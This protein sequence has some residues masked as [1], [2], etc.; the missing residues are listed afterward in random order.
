MS[1][2]F[3]FAQPFAPGDV[4][5]GSFVQLRTK[6][7][8]VI[9]TQQDQEST[10]LQDG[11]WKTVAISASLPDMLVGI[12][13]IAALSWSSANGGTVMVTTS[14]AHNLSTGQLAYIN[15]VFPVAYEASGAIPVTVTG[16]K[17]L[18]YPLAANPGTASFSPSGATLGAVIEYD[19]YSVPGAPN[20][21][22]NVTL[23][24]LVANSDLKLYFTGYDLGTDTWEVSV[25]DIVANGAGAAW[26]PTNGPGWGTN[27][28]RGW[29]VIRSGPVCTEWRFW[30]VLRRVSDGAFHPWLRGVLFVRAWGAAGPYEIG[31]YW[32]MPNIWGPNPASGTPTSVDTTLVQ[33]SGD[34]ALADS[35]GTV[36]TGSQALNYSDSSSPA[37]FGAVTASIAPSGTISRD[38]SAQVGPL[39]SASTYSWTH[40][41]AANASKLIVSVITYT[42]SGVVAASKITCG[43]IALTRIDG[44][45]DNNQCDTE[46]WYLD[47]PPAGAQTIAV[48]L[49]G[50]ADSCRGMSVSYIG[51]APG[52][53]SHANGQS[54][55]GT[56]FSLATSVVASN[57]WLVGN[58]F[59]GS[60]TL[61]AATTQVPSGSEP[62]HV[63]IATLQNG[64]TVLMYYGG[65]NDFRTAATAGTNAI[66]LNS[67][68]VALNSSTGYATAAVFT[69]TANQYRTLF[70]IT[71]N[72]YTQSRNTTAD[73][74]AGGGVPVVLSSTGSLP[75]GLT[76]GTVY[77]LAGVDGATKIAFAADAASTLK[78]TDNSGFVVPN[79]PTVTGV[80]SG[81]MTI[82]P[83]SVCFPACAVPAFDQNCR[84]VWVN[85]TQPT[86]LAAH[87]FNYLTTK[88]RCI[89][90]YIPA[91]GT[92]IDNPVQVDAS[93]SGAAPPPFSQSSI[94]WPFQ[95]GG[96]GDSAFDDRIGWLTWHSAC[97]LYR[98]FDN[99]LHQAN[100]C[101]AAAYF[102][103]GYWTADETVGLYSVINNTTYPY[104]AA[105]AGPNARWRTGAV[106]TVSISGAQADTVGG[107]LSG[108]HQAA[109]WILPY[110][111]TGDF[112]WYE[113]MASFFATRMMTSYYSTLTAGTA[114]A[115]K[116]CINIDPTVSYTLPAGKGSTGMYQGANE[117]DDS[118]Q[119]RGIGWI[120]RIF[121]TTRHFMP[122]SRPE[123]PYFN[124][125]LANEIALM[126][127][128]TTIN[129]T[130]SALGFLEAENNQ[131]NAYAPF[132]YNTYMHDYAFL[133]WA[134][135]AWKG[136][137]PAA[138]HFFANFFARYCPGRAN[139]S[140]AGNPG[141]IY[142]IGVYEQVVVDTN[143]NWIQTWDASI[144][145]LQAYTAGG[146]NF[147]AMVQYSQGSNQATIVYVTN[148]YT[149]GVGCPANI[150]N[151]ADF[152][153]Y[154]IVESNNGNVLTLNPTPGSATQP[155]ATTG[156]SVITM[157][158]A[159]SS[160]TT[161]N[162]TASPA[163]A[164]VVVGMGVYN[165]NNP[166][167]IPTGSVGV[168]GWPMT[169]YVT[170]VNAGSV[171]LSIPLAGQPQTTGA[172][173]GDTIA[174]G[175]IMNFSNGGGT[176]PWPGVATINAT[177]PFTDTMT[178]QPGLGG[179]GN[180][181]SYVCTYTSALAM[182]AMLYQATGNSSLSAAASA[183]A[184]IRRRQYLTVLSDGTTPNPTGVLSF[185]NAPKYAI[186]AIAAG[187]SAP[188]APAMLA[189]AEDCGAGAA[190]SWAANP[191][192]DGVTQ[193]AVYRAPQGAASAA[194]VATVTSPG[195]TDTDGALA[196][197]TSW[198]YYVTAHNT[199]G[200]SPPSPSVLAQ[201]P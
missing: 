59:T 100:L 96:T 73:G 176:E 183:Y 86:L 187:G 28:T 76:P 136:E 135:E 54:G 90:P 52:I 163:A 69:I 154:P 26:P 38:T 46:L 25:N 35:N 33:T 60:A 9:P 41:L 137:Y 193:Y 122:A 85:G 127:Q 42:G 77:W 197:G 192:G 169:T 49:S 56:R 66:P 164:G 171:T 188:G 107:D 125:Q 64:N 117:P 10:W 53:D 198:A 182:A 200:A 19:I 151:F 157:T 68:T 6:G 147:D 128:N 4:P 62:K 144:A 143:Y 58:V 24:Q 174:F 104:F 178:P 30:S 119:L 45:T 94:Y 75:G 17:T 15:G 159:A 168:G 83:L 79:F 70:G 184:E 194:Q 181:D 175:P 196:S 167:G 110:L 190:L 82:T 80:G 133:C 57:C 37:W 102:A 88:S 150:A 148:E 186:G 145:A 72:D 18:T 67:N 105:P 95:P 191:A 99:A 31:G 123:A 71:Y 120:M 170:A 7:G 165:V 93:I 114:T 201:I 166:M 153:G 13:G 91:A 177:F 109:P 162:L 3:T 81:A 139:Q 36:G 43:G 158:A 50:L 11:S 130:T 185:N 152:P 27:P 34:I 84:R 140:N 149:S 32:C 98:P 106:Y 155:L 22:A 1:I 173:A 5:A 61:V 141:C 40:T 131:Y 113:A 146:V 65:P 116:P 78:V 39:T 121:G 101:M 124:D 118:T 44:I 103:Y 180:P 129:Y 51:T 48:T 87:D 97:E 8:T 160:G 55:G 195:Y 161:L 29:E 21:A 2:F 134:M 63:F 179:Y 89:P 92:G 47:N 112:M 199:S 74:F 12:V 138:V 189:L 108:S 142:A 132:I 14:A 20:R 126:D 16:A 172:N 111:K 23:A 156:R 115:Y